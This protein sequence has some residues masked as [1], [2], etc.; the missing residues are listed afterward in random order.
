MILV[1]VQQSQKE[2]RNSTSTNFEIV[3]MDIESAFDRDDRLRTV[4][5]KENQKCDQETERKVNFVLETSSNSSRIVSNHENQNSNENEIL[6]EHMSKDRDERRPNFENPMV[7]S[8]LQTNK[9]EEIRSSVEVSS[10]YSN[11]IDSPFFQNA[12]VQQCI[13]CS[14]VRTPESPSSFQRQTLNK[15]NERNRNIVKRSRFSNSNQ[16]RSDP[17]AWSS[18]DRSNFTTKHHSNNRT[19][20]QM[21]TFVEES[22][23]SL[24][25]TQMYESLF[26]HFQL[27]LRSFS[28]FEK[29][30]S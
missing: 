26:L 20:P 28:E 8:Q 21:N 10:I 11:Q 23:P 24:M 4:E 25:E 18:T 6:F 14:P 12:K 17:T 15:S 29:T 9:E 3:E 19:Y 22:I 30:I 13:S 1:L 16:Q 2:R 5:S 27:I 7:L